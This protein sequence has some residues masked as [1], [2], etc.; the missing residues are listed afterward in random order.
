MTSCGNLLRGL[1]ISAHT[2]LTLIGVDNMPGLDTVWV[3]TL[4]FPPEGVRVLMG[5]SPNIRF[6][7]PE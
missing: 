6:L 4:P 2:K 5:Y 3:W 7:M 1:D